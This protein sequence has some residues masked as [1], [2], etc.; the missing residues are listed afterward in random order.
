MDAM[1]RIFVV[2]FIALFLLECGSKSEQ[3]RRLT[4][5]SRVNETQKFDDNVSIRVKNVNDSRCPTGCVC[6]WAGEVRVFLNISKNDYSMD[7][8]IILPSR[9]AIKFIDYFVELK[10]VSPYPLCDN[11]VTPDYIFTFQVSVLR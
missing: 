2:G 7:T 10:D 8:C 9:P 4:V 3:L 6:I 11:Q 5:S 1:L